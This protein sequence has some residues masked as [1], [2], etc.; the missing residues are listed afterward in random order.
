MERWRCKGRERDG[1]GSQGRKRE[2]EGKEGTEG[3]VDGVRK[4]R[5]GG[6]GNGGRGR[7]SQKGRW[8]ER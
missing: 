3:E 1:G 4:E 7:W 6:E 5:R 8:R 2:V